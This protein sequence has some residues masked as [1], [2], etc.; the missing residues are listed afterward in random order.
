MK[1]GLE[2]LG[3]MR[4]QA[5]LLLAVVFVIG[6]LVGFSLDRLVAP[7]GRPPHHQGPPPKGLPPELRDGMNL[8]ADQERRIQAIL[9]ASRPRTDA[10]LNEFLPRLRAIADSVRLEMR[11]VLTP[12]QRVLFDQREPIMKG[13][14]AG[15]IFDRPAD[16]PPPS[17]PPGRG[18]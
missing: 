17:P 4:L 6:G 5:V 3:Q 14:G 16:G 1:A 7:P 15:R 18:R 9:D 2:S 13:P 11:E 12:E 8:T 10:V